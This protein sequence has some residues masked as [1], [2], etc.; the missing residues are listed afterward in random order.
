VCGV[1]ECVCVVFSLLLLPDQ[2]QTVISGPFTAKARSQFQATSL[3]T[4]MGFPLS[5]VVIIIPLALH[6]NSFPLT[7]TI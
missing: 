2:A 1:G 3:D 7:Y 4:G 5:T 6:A